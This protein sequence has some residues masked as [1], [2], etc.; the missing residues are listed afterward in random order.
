MKELVELKTRL[1]KEVKELKDF[2]DTHPTIY[3][4]E[5]IILSN[6]FQAKKDLLTVV[7]NQIEFM[8]NKKFKFIKC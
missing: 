2:F 6:N 3:T 7:K 1:E 5:G 8:N 4:I